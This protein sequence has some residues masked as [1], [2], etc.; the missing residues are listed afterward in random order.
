MIR[1]LWL[2]VQMLYSQ[3]AGIAEENEVP[4]R[5]P[6][7]Q[8]NM[9]PGGVVYRPMNFGI[10]TDHLNHKDDRYVVNGVSTSRKVVEE[11]L[12]T[13]AKAIDDN[14]NKLWLIVIGTPEQQEVAKGSL[15]PTQIENFKVKYLTQEES[16]KKEL[17][18]V[19]DPSGPVIY[20]VNNAGVVMHR[21]TG[22]EKFYQ[23]AQSLFPKYDPKKD[24]DLR[25]AHDVTGFD[26]FK[27]D[28]SKLGFGGAVGAALMGLFNWWNKKRTTTSS[29]LADALAQINQ[30]KGQ[31]NATAVPPKG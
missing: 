21:Q 28:W 31:A 15:T 1:I 2:A 30:L 20:V 25:I 14:S 6:Y 27:N 24:P 5:M 18:Y 29:L 23:A 12:R 26:W 13:Q 3:H 11:Y 7:A 8:Y 9:Q 22:V 16:D 19:G 17:N 4:A 10:G